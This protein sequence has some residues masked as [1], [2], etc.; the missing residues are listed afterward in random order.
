MRAID[1]LKEFYIDERSVSEWLPWGGLVRAN[2]V[3]NK[4][5]SFFGVL[6]HGTLSAVVP[7]VEFPRGWSLWAEQ[8]HLTT[9]D[10]FYLVVCWNPFWKK[11]DHDVADNALMDR[12]IQRKQAVNYFSEELSRIAEGIRNSGVSC[13]ILEYQEIVDFLHILV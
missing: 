8:Q 9:S 6:A 4:D 5:D 10:R 2:V 3:K 13:R 7:A 1:R 11:R 12:T